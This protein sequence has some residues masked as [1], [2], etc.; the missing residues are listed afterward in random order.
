MRGARGISA[1]TGAI[2]MALVLR[3]GP[4]L[5]WTWPRL[6][7][8]LGLAPLP[9]GVA[10]VLAIGIIGWVMGWVVSRP[11][12]PARWGLSLSIG[13]ALL[14][15]H[16]MHAPMGFGALGVAATAR[17]WGAYSPDPD[18]P[19]HTLVAA[20]LWVAVATG[21]CPVLGLIG[22]ISVGWAAR[23]LPTAARP[24]AWLITGFP[25]AALLGIAAYLT[26]IPGVLR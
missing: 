25:S 7:S 2:G 17:A 5:P 8:P 19:V 6:L 4:T 18:L 23:P 15:L 1:L 14:L 9:A 11:A 16:G 26:E 3:W 22:W 12:R 21:C 13:G 10:S 24:A 20:G